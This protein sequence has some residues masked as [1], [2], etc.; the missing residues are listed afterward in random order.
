MFVDEALWLRQV[1]ARLELRS[2]SKVLDIG[3]STLDFRTKVQ[4]HI[5]E[6]VFAPLRAMGVAVSHLDARQDSGVDI[7]AD[8]TTLEGVPAD[9]DVVICTSLLEHVVDRAETARN[10]CR[11]VKPGG[12]LILTVPRR[13]PIHRDPIDT[14]YRP[15]PEQ[16]SALI[17]WP[18]VLEKQ[19]LT[20]RDAIHYRGLRALRR[21]LLPW[22]ISCLVA[23]RQ[24]PQS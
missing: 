12:T 8:I 2:G 15:S 24:R 3:S 1:L 16:L 11:V 20:I 13:Y 5:D 10:I 18:E 22:Q 7:V 21:F 14:G 6:H 9:F 23:T 19:V 17:A 4:P